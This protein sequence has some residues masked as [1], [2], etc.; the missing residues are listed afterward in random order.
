MENQEVRPLSLR[1][2]LAT[3]FKRK[4]LITVI[5]LLG[6][7]GV[8]VGV[9]MWPKTYEASA[10]ILVKLG[11]ENI[12]ISTLS[13]SAQSK[14]MTSLQ[15][16]IEDINSEIEILVKRE[17]IEKLIDKLGMDFLAPKGVRKWY[18]KIKDAVINGIKELMYMLKLKKRLTP[19][20][21]LVL[22]LSES[23]MVEQIVRSDIIKV[24]LQWGD[25]EIARVAVET[26]LE[27]YLESHIDIHKTSEDFTFLQQQVNHTR[28]QLEDHENRLEELKLNEGIVSYPDQQRLLLERRAEL[29][30]AKK[31]VETELVG[32]RSEIEEYT[33]ELSE[34]SEVVKLDSKFNRNPILD[35]LKTKLLNLELKKAQLE[36]KFL[37]DSRPIVDIEKD[38]LKVKAKLAS[39][40]ERVTGVVTMGVNKIYESTRKGL[41]NTRVRLSSLREKKD[42]LERQLLWYDEKLKR[43]SYSETELKRLDRLIEI[44]GGNY[45]LYRKRL[46]EARMA[47]LLD[48]RRVVNVTVIERPVATFF[49]IKPK[50]LKVIGIGI[51]LSLVTG[52][53]LALLLD[54]L[55]HTLHTTEEVDRYVGLRVLASIPEGVKGLKTNGGKT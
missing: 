45:R 36:N 19:Y 26:L 52:I 53:A 40:Q 21:Q 4:R 42:I 44:E 13:E 12:A 2:F 27:L 7:I 32:A 14:V 35:P 46:E 37:K 47:N 49:P 9:Y 23:L 18:Q 48:D 10:K 29:E 33:K 54:Y 41:I 6:V 16:R 43:L 34:E 50:K 31:L 38:I 22:G 15:V 30:V 24:T 8:T 28:D 17:L 51:L 3:L 20:E 5:F 1:D 39:E 11:R 25:P 55:D